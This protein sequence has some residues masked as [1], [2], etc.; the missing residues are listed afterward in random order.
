MKVLAFMVSPF[1]MRSRYQAMLTFSEKWGGS[2]RT[3]VI[4]GLLY[5]SYRNERRKQGAE[6]IHAII[7]EQ[8]I[9]LKR[10]AEK[11]VE[12]RPQSRR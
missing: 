11:T 3:T 5:E 9:V 6:K 1:L 12:K 8:M 10:R 7:V 4:A 2:T